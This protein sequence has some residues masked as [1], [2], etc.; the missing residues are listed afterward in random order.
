[1]RA[2]ARRN[3]E[4]IVA[5]AIRVFTETGC[6]VSMEEIARLAGVGVGT[7]YRHFPDRTS[8]FTV[9]A[10]DV[11]RRLTESLAAAAAGDLPRWQVLMDYVRD[12]V[13][14]PLS[15]LKSIDSEDE[16]L[17][18]LQERLRALLTEVIAGAQVEGSLR[19][20]IEVDDV[21]ELFR[22][23]VCRPGASTD[24]ALATVVLDGLR[25]DA[26]AQGV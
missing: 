2:D 9:I 24:D 8:L 11:L 6:A 18:A 14:E 1:M 16:E 5:A 20:D 22:M 10:C 23:V 4:Q 15:M 7:I 26:L 12:S 3:R 21:I 25:G 19:A 17:A 13:S